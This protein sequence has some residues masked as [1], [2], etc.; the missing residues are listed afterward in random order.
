MTLIAYPVKHTAWKTALLISIGIIFGT[1]FFITY[2]LLIKESHF[3]ED[4]TVHCLFLKYEA[5][6][7][8][9]QTA[10]LVFMCSAI[11]LSSAA[12]IGS[13]LLLFLRAGGHH[14]N[15]A[16]LSMFILALLDFFIE[17]LFVSLYFTTMLPALHL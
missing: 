13:V 5:D 1:P 12:N 3:V 10:T 16:E 2:N 6:L 8:P 11:A 14:R 15:R 17:A 9:L 7:H 4:D